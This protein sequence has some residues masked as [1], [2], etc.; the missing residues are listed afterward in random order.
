MQALDYWTKITEKKPYSDL[1]WNIP[2]QKTGSVNIIGGNSSSFAVVAKTAEYVSSSFPIRGLNILLPD[3]LRNKVPPI[4]G[5]NFL[6]STE[7]GSFA[8]SPLM[9]EYVE[10]ADFTIFIGDLSK[11]SATS[12]AISDTLKNTTKRVL[13][14]RD[15]IDIA[16]PEMVNII[17]REGLFIVG[18]MMQLQ[19]LF[20]AVYYP[21][22]ILL[23]Q[24]LL[25]IIETLHKF[26]LSY[27]V[28]IVTFH[29]EQI[30]IANGGKINTVPISN[31]NYNPLSLWNGELAAK[32]A[33]NNLYTPGKPLEATTFS[34]N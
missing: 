33:L 28:T 30:I 12:I 34:I 10:S 20:R 31:T 23:S 27:P 6:P 21:K 18:S 17:D 11:N 29:Q 26:T 25:P 4:V 8:K 14:T 3:S 2:E 24:P 1:E 22:M 5:V 16:G 19:K 7:S 13:L 15:A 32:I 9:A